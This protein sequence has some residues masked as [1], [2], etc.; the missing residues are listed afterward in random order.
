MI[1]IRFPNSD[2]KRMA[3]GFLV[4]RFSCTTYRTGE[5]LVPSEAL[6]E[7]A[8]AGIPF[9]VEGRATYR[10]SIPAYHV[11]DSTERC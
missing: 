7:L 10:Q 2:A 1:V 5:M 3:L 8:I 4:R 9:S 6:G 11:A